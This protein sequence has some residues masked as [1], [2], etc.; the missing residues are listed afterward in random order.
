MTN[1]KRSL[2][3]DMVF[4]SVGSLYY[5]VCQ[6]LLTVLVVP[7]CSFEA[8]GILALAISLTNVFFTLATFGIRIFQVSDSHGKYTPGR[9]I[10][11]RVLTC[12][13]SLG[14]C[15]LFLLCNRQ[16]TAEQ[17]LCIL[18]YMLYRISEALVDVLAGEE[19]KAYRFDYVGLSFFFRGTATLLSFTLALYFTR[20]LTLTLLLMALTV[21]CVVLVYD[22]K[23][24]KTLTDFRLRL[25][26]RDSLPLLKEAW[27]LMLNSALLTLLAAIPRYFLEMY[28]G[29]EL[30]GY[31]GSVSTPAVIIQAGCSFIYTPL[32][33]PLSERFARGSLRDFRRML[34][35]ALCG[36]LGFAACMFAGAAVLGQW[37]LT[38]LFGQD[39]LPYAF[40]LLPVLGSALCVSLIYFFEVPLTIGRQLKVM[41]VIH[42]CAAALAAVV[43]LAAI[44]G[45]GLQGVLLALY[46]SA[47]ADVLAMAAVTARM[48]R[49]SR[50]LSDGTRG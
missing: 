39:I 28:H 11:T 5:L 12:L 50:P 49:R 41:T 46:L 35:L 40:L 7:L 20:N 4:N 1:T 13:C 38:L 33:A 26:L 48:C 34:L 2:G 8:A 25:S 10:S 45:Q 22:G 27:P 29:S 24:V 43:S 37:G 23:R 15:A 16:Y 18:F 44:P 47:G 3:R 6:W 17:V 14:L 9:Y 32:V 42:A 31:F 30:L 19:Q 21:L 36:V